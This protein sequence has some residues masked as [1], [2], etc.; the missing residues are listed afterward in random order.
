MS[1]VDLHIHSTVS[2]G[3][4]SPVD[5][6]R[7]AAEQGL[8]VIAIADHDTV[9]GIVPAIE[10]AKAFPEL[11]VIPAIELSTDVPQGEV[12]VLGYF[13]DCNDRGFQATLERMRHSRL[14]RAQGMI[15]KLKNFGI[16]IDW[17]R[18]QEIAGEGSMGRP[19]IAQA[20]LEKG[21]VTSFKEAFDR[22]ISRDG[23]AYVERE[24][25]TPVEAVELLLQVNG[26]PVLAHP[27]TTKNPERLIVELKAAGLIGIEA[28]SHGY[29]TDEI[30]RLVSLADK[31]G[32]ITTGGSDYHGQATN[33]TM[34]GSVD[35]PI[36]S[37]ERLMALA[38]RQA[39]KP[40]R[41]DNPNR[42]TGDC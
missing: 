5:I 26:L 16:Y 17:E 21:H 4:L 42:G 2:D 3:R 22:Y 24:K 33:E 30:S 13:I 6:V 29:T 14:H 9:D 32:L 25:M 27:F 40:A 10:A 41:V 35:V 23:P 39:L 36:E 1:K 31:Y 34:I 11:K 8:S 20:M 37:V 18:V 19:H 28:Y 38:K 7:Q 15:A 12:H